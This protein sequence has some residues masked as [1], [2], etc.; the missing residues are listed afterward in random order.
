[1]VTENITVVG[2]VPISLPLCPLYI[3]HA[4]LWNWT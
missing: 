1:M 3:P 4:L 2:G